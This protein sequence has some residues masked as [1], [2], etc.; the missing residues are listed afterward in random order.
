[1]VKTILKASKSTNI[2]SFIRP[3][4]GKMIGNCKL[5]NEN[6]VIGD[7]KIE[8]LSKACQRQRI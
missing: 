3:K 5:V 7:K 8:Y 6:Q 4:N 1:M 2:R